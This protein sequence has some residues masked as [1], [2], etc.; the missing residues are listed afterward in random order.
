MALGSGG[1]VCWPTVGPGDTSE[2]ATTLAPSW[3]CS[4]R[5]PEQR[6]R[7]VLPVHKAMV[8]LLGSQRYLVSLRET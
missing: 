2:A 4:T 6:G 8:V 1:G 5:S 3:P 7:L